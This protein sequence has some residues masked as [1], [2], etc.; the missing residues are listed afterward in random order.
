MCEFKTVVVCSAKLIYPHRVYSHIKR[1]AQWRHRAG[2]EELPQI[3]NLSCCL[4]SCILRVEM[5]AIKLHRVE[6]CLDVEVSEAV[7]QR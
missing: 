7:A 4:E 1:Y 5:E 6:R 2:G 3:G